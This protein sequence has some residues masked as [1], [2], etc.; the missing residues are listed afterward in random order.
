MNDT[1]HTIVLA[2]FV[3]ASCVWVGGYVAI[4]V[5]ARV[6]VHT[7]DTAQRI[8]FFRGLGRSYLRVGA[9]ALAIALA[10]GAVLCE[11]RSWDATLVATAALAAAL[12]IALAVGVMQARRMTRRRFASLAAPHDDQLARG[13]QR[14][15]RAAAVLRACIGVLTV[16]LVALGSVLAV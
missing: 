6:A 9:P 12:V 5:V 10:T 11:D 1:V 2:L 3:L 4:A 13:V 16:L 8:A 7:L 15:A 14:G